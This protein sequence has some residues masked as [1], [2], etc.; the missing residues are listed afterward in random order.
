[1]SPTH[2]DTSESYKGPHCRCRPQPSQANQQAATGRWPIHECPSPISHAPKST[3]PSPGGRWGTR[4]QG[5]TLA[6]A[7]TPEQ[8][9][10]AASSALIG[11]QQL[12][13]RPLVKVPAL[14]K[15]TGVTTTTTRPLRSPSWERTATPAGWTDAATPAGV[16]TRLRG[17]MVP[18]TKHRHPGQRQGHPH[19]GPH[20]PKS[21]IPTVP[22][23][24]HIPLQLGSK[25]KKTK[26]HNK[27]YRLEWKV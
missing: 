22:E 6:R 18:G 8:L 17:L 27:K 15:Q 12:A 21:L 7:P 10:P 11:R 1:M 19:I 13:Q 4:R 9:P 26:R 14:I 3:A 2:C 23:L 20:A 24:L 5:R 25:Q 16:S